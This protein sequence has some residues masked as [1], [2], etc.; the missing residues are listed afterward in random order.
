MHQKEMYVSPHT[1]TQYENVSSSNSLIRFYVYKCGKA[2]FSATHVFAVCASVHYLCGCR[3]C[4][5][6][7]GKNVIATS[8]TA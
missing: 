1:Q 5:M 8:V 7:P 2:I 3:M 4:S 6:S